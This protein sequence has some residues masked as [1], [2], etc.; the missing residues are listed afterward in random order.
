MD[1]KEDFRTKPMGT[2]GRADL[3]DSMELEAL[4]GMAEAEADMVHNLAATEAEA[5][6]LVVLPLRHPLALLP[7]RILSEWPQ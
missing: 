2:V 5:L 1:I 3:A 7:V 6:D 4:V